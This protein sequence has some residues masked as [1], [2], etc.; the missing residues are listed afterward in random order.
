M[1]NGFN[2][3]WGQ[4]G[5][6]LKKMISAVT[7]LECSSKTQQV[8]ASI[9]LDSTFFETGMKLMEPLFLSIQSNPKADDLWLNSIPLLVAECEVSFWCCNKGCI[10]ATKAKEETAQEKDLYFPLIFHPK[11]FYVIELK[12]YSL[13]FVMILI[14]KKTSVMDELCEEAH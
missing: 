2:H 13:V 1:D 5:E 8:N 7:Y 4:Q 10:E 6:E 9:W 12:P 11:S 14:Y 3:D